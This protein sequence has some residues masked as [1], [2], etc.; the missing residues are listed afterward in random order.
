MPAQTYLLE[1]FR[2]LFAS[3]KTGGLIWI[4]HHCS[5]PVGH[6]QISGD[7]RQLW[8]VNLAGLTLQHWINDGLMAEFFL[9]MGLELESELYNGELSSFRNALPLSSLRR[10]GSRCPRCFIT[11]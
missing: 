11:A 3:R 6:S 10:A 7:Y 5:A 1:I 2:R 9:F 4:F 8:S